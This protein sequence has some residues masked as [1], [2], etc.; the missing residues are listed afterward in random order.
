MTEISEADWE[1]LSAFHDGE[2]DLARQADF[3]RRLSRE[4]ALAAALADLGELS[5]DLRSLR[6]APARPAGS[7]RPTRHLRRWIAGGSL[8][9]G[10]AALMAFSLGDEPPASIGAIHAEFAAREIPFADHGPVAIAGPRAA[11]LPDLGLAGLTLVAKQDMP[12]GVAGHYAGRNGCRLTLIVGDTVATEGPLPPLR[13]SWSDGSKRYLMLAEG[14]DAARFDA[15][16]SFARLAD[17][18]EVRTAL[19]GALET[20]P[21]CT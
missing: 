7:A 8:A 21:T 11:G 1:L 19:A 9:A 5:R 2:L 14:M 13:D 12:G 6:P 17:G 16:A 15:I 10:F 4:P 3:G 18:P 20:T